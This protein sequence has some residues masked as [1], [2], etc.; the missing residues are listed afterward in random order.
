MSDT[1][2]TDFTL[3]ERLGKGSYAVVYRAIKKTTKEIFAIKIME[4]H[5]LSS[6]AIDNVVSEIGLLKRLKHP[7]IVEMRDFLWD[8]SNIYIVME[9]CNAG[10]LSSYIKA[11][12]TLSESTCKM[13]LQ[14]LA[15]ALRYMRTHDVSHLDL[16]PANLLLHKIANK[17]VLKVA[18]FGFAQRLKLNQE[19]TAV[20]GSP[21]YMAPEILISKSYGA[22]ADLWS[23]GVILYEC[24]FGKPPYSSASVQELAGRIQN[25]T[26]ISIPQK[27]SIST[28][29][30]KLLGHLL[31]RDPNQ[32]ITFEKFFEDAFLDLKCVPNEENLDKAIQLIKDAIKMDEAHNI[33][34]AYHL[35][36][37]ALQY[38]VPITLAETDPSRKRILRQRVQT[39]LN[40]AEALKNIIHAKRA[41]PSSG[42]SNTT[43]SALHKVTVS[44]SANQKLTDP[45]SA[46]SDEPERMLAYLARNFEDVARGFEIVRKAIDDA[47]E[48]RLDEALEGFTTALGILI[49]TLEVVGPAPHKKLL[50]QKIVR[51]MEEAEHIKSMRS[52][53]ILENVENTEAYHSVCVVQ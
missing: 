7:H 38:F 23:V 33:S 5:K 43:S 34:A 12:K 18:D 21:L 3:M 31:Q 2:I 32:R 50:Q 9:Y 39:Y 28:D 16:K 11:N 36:C 17:Y 14:Q 44:E 46:E 52:A 13:F 42:S 49:P 27:P 41:P 25:N 48:N 35:Y 10:N 8:Q 29:C 47:L 1:K 24:L 51:W 22:A 40:R 45:S 53:Q 4:Q 20:K 19:N 15:L 6:S 30:R 26:P 37:Q